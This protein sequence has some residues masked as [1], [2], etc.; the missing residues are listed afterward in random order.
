[1]GHTP[2][3]GALRL[4]EAELKGKVE[5]LCEVVL[6]TDGMETCHGNPAIEAR[7]L[8][9]SLKLLN[10]V[11]VVGFDINPKERE[12]VK[13][14]AE[15]GAGKAERAASEA[16]ESAGRAGKTGKEAV[17]L[18]TESKKGLEEARQVVAEVKKAEDA[19]AEA[20]AAARKARKAA[21]DAAAARTADDA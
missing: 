16:R 1:M 15:G 3:A 18:A 10:G 2:I 21:T 5:G 4:L 12:A 8:A 7:R 6:I 20:G 17:T 14:I 9:Q 11:N 19:A 13:Q